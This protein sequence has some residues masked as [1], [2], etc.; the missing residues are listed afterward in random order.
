MEAALSLE[1]MPPPNILRTAAS[2]GTESR[3]FG[4]NCL[5]QLAE[6]FSVLTANHLRGSTPSVLSVFISLSF[7]LLTYDMTVRQR[8]FNISI[9][10][11]SM[12]YLPGLSS[13]VY[14]KLLVMW[15]KLSSTVLQL[16]DVSG[17][18]RRYPS[19]L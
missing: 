11:F 19:I 7:S 14:A 12:D 17:Y 5:H 1:Y 13:S 3:P 10:L 4:T 15:R 9:F 18:L 8:R 6:N 2:K 16:G